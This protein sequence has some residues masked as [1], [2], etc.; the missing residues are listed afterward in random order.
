MNII[1]VGDKVENT[2]GEPVTVTSVETGKYGLLVYGTFHSCTDWFG[3]YH[4]YE[5]PPI[6]TE[7]DFYEWATRGYTLLSD[8]SRLGCVSWWRGTREPQ[9]LL[10]Y[11]ES[12]WE[13]TLETMRL[14]QM[15]GTHTPNNTLQSRPFTEQS[16]PDV[17]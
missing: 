4:P 11:L 5:L 2:H 17:L 10:A 13:R 7:F 6:D 16:R 3:A 15:S 8:G 9:Q 1:E 14:E 12:M